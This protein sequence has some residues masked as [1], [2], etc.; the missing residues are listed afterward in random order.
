MFTL[1]CRDSGERHKNRQGKKTLTWFAS[2]LRDVDPNDMPMN[3]HL[4]TR[5]PQLTSREE[6]LRKRLLEFRLA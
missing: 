6:D 2:Y 4:R 3:D 5:G 1:P